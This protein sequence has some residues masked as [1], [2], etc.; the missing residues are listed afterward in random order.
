M[1]TK[2]KTTLTSNQLLR[3]RLAKY[4]KWGA[5][6]KKFGRKYKKEEAYYK[7]R[8]KATNKLLRKKR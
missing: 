7:K 1:A 5:L 8:I 2:R 6:Y 4:K 3:K